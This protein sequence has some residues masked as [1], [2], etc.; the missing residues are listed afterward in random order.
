MPAPKRILVVDD[1][2]SGAETIRLSLIIDRHQVEVAEDGETAL[3]MFDA[4]RHDLV[5]TDFKMPGM[6]GLELAQAIRALCSAQPIMLVTA[7]L[8]E[9]A[10]DNVTLSNVDN[11]LGKP[12]SVARLRAAV[13]ALFP[14]A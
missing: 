3:A 5:I 8:E 1:E 10:R 9:L 4:G 2:P 7:H 6:D 14:A 12:F 13:A 11:V